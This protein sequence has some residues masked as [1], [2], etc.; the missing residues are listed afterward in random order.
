[1]EKEL[2]ERCETIEQQAEKLTDYYIAKDD[3]VRQRFHSSCRYV[4]KERL[5]REELA[6]LKEVKVTLAETKELLLSPKQLPEKK[7]SIEGD[8]RAS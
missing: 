3:K 7:A 5:S 4:S 6:Q 1:M 8:G 2:L